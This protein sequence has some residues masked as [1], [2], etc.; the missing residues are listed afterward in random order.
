MDLLYLACMVLALFQMG[1]AGG[2][3]EPLMDVEEQHAGLAAYE[4]LLEDTPDSVLNAMAA[5][6]T[7]FL[8]YQRAP[9]LP[10]PFDSTAAQQWVEATLA[11]LSVDEKI[12]QLFIVHLARSGLRDLVNDPALTAV[13]KFGVGGFLISRL[14]PPRSVYERTQQLQAAAKAPLLIAAD[15]ERG[16]G[17]FNN[18]LTEFPSNMAIGATRDTVLAAAAGRLT[19]IE[20]RATGVNL[21]FAPVV[22]VNNNPDNPIINIRSYGED[23][24]LVGQMA[25][26]YVKEAETHGV[27]T[28][29]KHF[30]GHGNTSVDSHSHMGV[31]HAGRASLDSV[32]LHPYQVVLT[33]R[34]PPSGVMSA[35]LWIK[36]LDETPQPATFSRRALTDLLRDSLGFGGFVVTDDIKMGALQNTYSMEERILRPLE[37]GAD[38]ILTPANLEKAVQVVRKAVTQGR[39]SEEDLDRSV[40]RVLWAKARAGLHTERHPDRQD[41]DYLLEMPHGAYLAQTIA[42]RALTLLKTSPALP[43]E[44][45]RRIALVQLSNYQNSESID[46]AMS[47]FA[48]TLGG[49]GRRINETRFDSN[50]TQAQR[51]KVVRDAQGADVVVLA[52]YLRLQ[53]GRGEAGLF[54]QQERLARSL[55]AGDTPV[56]LVTFG[57]PYAVTTFSEADA[58]LVAYDQTLESAR[59]AAHIL[60]GLQDPLGRLPITVDPYPFGS[61]LDKVAP[62]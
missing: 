20:S 39:V 5:L 53:S 57:N 14:M 18:A 28:T 44:P 49:D 11:S 12:G 21:V 3:E 8:D 15:Y 23:P 52:L 22:D 46:A 61:G 10:A 1:C 36:A 50:P 60:R 2:E 32:E 58:F 34:I 45:G 59:A 16:V 43:L 9:F 6:D 29:L 38:I 19:A 37:A 24:D 13:K 30:P 4:H 33:Q 26:A 42:D 31:I 47:Y 55:L 56:V 17:R 51:E 40:R 7:L 48:D 27:L 25:A 35:H 62:R 41:L 54:A